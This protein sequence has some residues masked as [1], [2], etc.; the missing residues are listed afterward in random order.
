MCCLLYRRVCPDSFLSV[1]VAYFFIYIIYYIYFFIYIL[2][3]SIYSLFDLKDYSIVYHS[4]TFKSVQ[5]LGAGSYFMF[6]NMFSGV[7]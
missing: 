6:Y 3:Y 4:F 2:Q 1:P 7:W 5:G